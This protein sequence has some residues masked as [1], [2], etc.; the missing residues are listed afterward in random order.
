M[1]R[2]DQPITDIDGIGPKTQEK[3]RK[4]ISTRGNRIF[5][6]SVTVFD[7]ESNQVKSRLELSTNQQTNLAAESSFSPSREARQKARE[8][9][10]QS[11]SR[12]QSDTIGR[13]DFRV[14]R[15]ELEEATEIF[16]SL[17]D[18]QQSEDKSSREPVTTNFGLW[19]EN[20]DVLDF[21]SVDTPQSRRPRQEGN[22]FLLN[23]TEGQRR[24]RDA[25][26][27]SK[28]KQTDSMAQL[29]ETPETADAERTGIVRN[30][31]GAF[32][33][34]PLTPDKDEDQYRSK[35]GF[36]VGDEVQDPT[37]GR[38]PD[39]GEFEDRPLDSEPSNSVPDP[40][41]FFK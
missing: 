9:G 22:D 23:D 37:I 31:D 32:V 21:P 13:G 29:G 28:P 5:G 19:K 39:T 3:L 16:N 26:R 25:W 7:V 40:F 6:D 38:D 15:E 36:V 12:Q 33:S 8:K 27:K 1:A 34:R 17:S 4:R 18:E 35:N 41:N 2:Q 20:V 14:G 10:S 30:E 24:P 11:R